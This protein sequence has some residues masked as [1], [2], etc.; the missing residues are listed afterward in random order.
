VRVRTR[1]KSSNKTSEE[2]A[3]VQASGPGRTRA[4]T[5]QVQVERERSRIDIVQASYHSMLVLIHHLSSIPV[6][7]Q[8][9]WNKQ[10]QSRMTLD[11][12]RQGT[13][14]TC[15]MIV[16]RVTYS[17]KCM[18]DKCMSAKCMSDKGSEMG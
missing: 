17:W 1:E 9:Q 4:V 7:W 2:C 5:H 11:P 15:C 8:I 6:P 13:F 10:S 12:C 14:I 18:S 3:S 16:S